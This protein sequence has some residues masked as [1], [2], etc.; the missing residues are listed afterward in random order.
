MKEKYTEIPEFQ[1]ER[2]GGKSTDFQT[3]IE[4]HLIQSE[5]TWLRIQAK[6]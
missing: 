3:V 2:I 1:T 4:E 6:T 5:N